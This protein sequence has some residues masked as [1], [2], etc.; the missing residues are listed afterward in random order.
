MMIFVVATSFLVLK[1]LSSFL[2][3]ETS[4]PVGQTPSSERVRLEIDATSVLRSWRTLKVKTA[5][6]MKQRCG[7]YFN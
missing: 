7:L 5:E 6:R 4:R 1:D 2:C 3:V